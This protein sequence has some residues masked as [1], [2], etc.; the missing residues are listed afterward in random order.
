MEKIHYQEIVKLLLKKFRMGY[1]AEFD[2]VGKDV[3]LV[4]DDTTC[5]TWKFDPE[6]SGSMEQFLGKIETTL[7]PNN[8]LIDD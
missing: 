6:D 7:F 1:T 3:L 8:F 5:E 4:T 2:Y